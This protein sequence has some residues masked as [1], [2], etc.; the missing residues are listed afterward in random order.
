MEITNY[1]AINKGALKAKFDVTIAQWGLTSNNVP[2]L[3]MT[4]SDG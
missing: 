3:T 4:V 2:I 1:I